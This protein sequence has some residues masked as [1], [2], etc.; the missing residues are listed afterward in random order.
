MK[1]TAEKLGERYLKKNVI[2]YLLII[3]FNVSLL[4]SIYIV[5]KYNW[6]KKVSEPCIQSTLSAYTI[7][8]E[9]Q[10]PSQIPP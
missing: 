8:R 4:G 1:R 6:N 5:Y 10:S 3:I 2:K 7:I 9:G